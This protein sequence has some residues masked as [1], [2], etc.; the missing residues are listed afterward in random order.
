MES[1]GARECAPLP[2]IEKRHLM[3]EGMRHLEDCTVRVSFFDGES[4]DD[5]GAMDV[6]FGCSRTMIYLA[7]SPVLEM[8]VSAEMASPLGPIR[9]HCN[10]H[11]KEAIADALEY[12][13]SRESVRLADMGMER[14][15]NLFGVL[16]WW[17]VPSDRVRDTLHDLFSRDPGRAV[18]NGFGLW[19]V[20]GEWPPGFP[21]AKPSTLAPKVLDWMVQDVPDAD[22][23]AAAQY[24]CDTCVP[25]VQVGMHLAQAQRL[26]PEVVRGLSTRLAI[27]DFLALS[28]RTELVEQVAGDMLR[29][30]RNTRAAI[31]ET[32]SVGYT[33]YS[34]LLSGD[35]L[36]KATVGHQRVGRMKFEDDGRRGAC[37][38]ATHSSQFHRFSTATICFLDRTRTEVKS[39]RKFAGVT[40]SKRSEVAAPLVEALPKHT[41]YGL[42]VFY[43]S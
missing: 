25:A 41:L 20:L 7:H 6:E 30:A 40:V 42:V 36:P 16:H 19:R 14:A 13:H 29:R 21:L 4:K 10:G 17:D 27:P 22:L 37:I 2:P 5:A 18:Q 32:R 28:T 33:A 38:G 24:A 9:F 1:P 39:D 11:G 3:P 35:E 43:S 26:T 23:P 31:E 12:V 15:C 34:M 8:L